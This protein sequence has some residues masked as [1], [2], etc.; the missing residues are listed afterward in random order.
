MGIFRFSSF[1]SAMKTHFVYLNK[2]LC[3]I[4]ICKGIQFG[5][6]LAE[7]ACCEKSPSVI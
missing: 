4:Y 1:I 5:A 6:G 7:K 3:Y 2:K